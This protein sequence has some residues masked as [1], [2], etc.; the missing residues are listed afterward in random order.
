MGL[1]S[2][3]ACLMDSTG[4]IVHM[5][6]DK[7]QSGREHRLPIVA[8]EALEVLTVKKAQHTLRGIAVSIGPGDDT[9]L[10]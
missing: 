5:S 8:K 1:D 9:R 4:S 10:L 2:S 3:E 7:G 6:D